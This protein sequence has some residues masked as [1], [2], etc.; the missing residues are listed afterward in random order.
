M[1][2]APLA[3]LGFGFVL[4]LRHALDVDHLAAVSTIV[5]RGRTL[6]R[7]ALVGAA[8]GLGH[9]ASLLAVAVGVVAL[10]TEIP[11]ALAQGLELAV[12]AMLVV[13]GIRLLATVVRGG[14]LHAHVHTHGHGPHIHPHLHADAR[15]D[16]DHVPGGRRSFLVGLVHGLAGS[17]SVMLSVVA[18][19]PNPALALVYVAV[20]GVGSIGG[21]MAMSTLMGVPSMVTATR[22]QSA[23]RWLRAGAAVAS[24]VVGLDLAWGIGRDSGL[25]A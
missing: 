5:G 12:A 2:T 11:P 9:T 7:S 16:H 23:D 17:A 13:L 24:V 22:F 6:W 18:T 21:M 8:W 14:A 1:S 25:L 19:I 15:D 20:F 3:L 4:G 10:H